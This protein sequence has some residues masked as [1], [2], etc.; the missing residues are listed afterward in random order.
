VSLRETLGRWDRLAPSLLRV[1][2]LGAPALARTRQE[3]ALRS[4][5]LAEPPSM[6][7]IEELADRFRTAIADRAFDEIP[8]RDWARAAFALW[9]GE[10][11]LAANESFLGAY[12]GRLGQR[13]RRR[14]VALLA[15]A[16]LRAFSPSAPAIRR[17]GE[18]LDRL[19]R[20]WEWSWAARQRELRLFDPERG[21]AALAQECLADEEPARALAKLG[22]EHLHGRA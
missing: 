14:D 9:H 12:L 11:P 20:L 6:E 21:P 8:D 18:A 17:V 4:S 2:D 22:L 7:S 5:G 13:R 19:V 1:K 15:S 10:M 3:L 16:Y